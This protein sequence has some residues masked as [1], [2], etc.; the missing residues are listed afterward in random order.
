MHALFTRQ[1][2]DV[3]HR[4]PAGYNETRRRLLLA[5]IQRYIGSQTQ[6]CYE[7]FLSTGSQIAALKLLSQNSCVVRAPADLGSTLA[8]PLVQTCNHLFPRVMQRLLTDEIPNDVG[9]FPLVESGT[10]LHVFGNVIATFIP[11][12]ANLFALVKPTAKNPSRE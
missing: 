7:N 2:I 5:R 12:N 6:C 3:W 9:V 11:P 8:Q 4:I 1:P 10:V